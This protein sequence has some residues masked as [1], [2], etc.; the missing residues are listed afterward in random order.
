MFPV[1][2]TLSLCVCVCVVT[3]RAHVDVVKARNYTAVWQ[4]VRLVEDKDRHC[5]NSR[6]PRHQQ[7]YVSYVFA[8][9]ACR[10]AHICTLCS[11]HIRNFLPPLQ[12]CEGGQRAQ[13]RGAALWCALE[14]NKKQKQGVSW[15]RRVDLRPKTKVHTQQVSA[16]GEVANSAAPVWA[17]TFQNLS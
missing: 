3:H 8:D 11:V 7:P 5:V 6:Q 2:H 1:S 13:G 4:S 16:N 15:F 14:K 17:C 12:S 9:N 10:M